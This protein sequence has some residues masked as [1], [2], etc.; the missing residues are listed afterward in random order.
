MRL[1]FVDVIERE[2]GIESTPP[3]ESDAFTEAAAGFHA[4]AHNRKLRPASQLEPFVFLP[5]VAKLIGIEKRRCDRGRRESLGNKFA[6]PIDN[7]RAFFFVEER[8]KRGGEN[9]HSLY[10]R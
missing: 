4:G 9:V 10:R 6:H 7:L 2:P 8:V 3:A 1:I 5:R